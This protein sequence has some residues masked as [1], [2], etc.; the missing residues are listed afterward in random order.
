M[1]GKE[2]NEHFD[3]VNEMRGMREIQG[4]L[5]LEREKA[6]LE[7]EKLSDELAFTKN[8]LERVQKLNS[9]MKVKLM[10]K[11]EADIVVKQLN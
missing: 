7:I 1:V 11:N 10:Q 6:S 8:D 3:K 2:R 4:K 9:E 5:E